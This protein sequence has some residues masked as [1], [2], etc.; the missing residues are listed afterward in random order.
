MPDN[1]RG[2]KIKVGQG[3]ERYAELILIW[4]RLGGGEPMESNSAECSNYHDTLVV[5]MRE[6][7]SHLVN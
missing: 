3:E 4:P 7:S 2:T 6:K 1:L 5:C